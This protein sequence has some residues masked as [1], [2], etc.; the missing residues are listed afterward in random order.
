MVKKSILIMCRIV[1]IIGRIAKEICCVCN[2]IAL[3]G[4]IV[5]CFMNDLVTY[6]IFRNV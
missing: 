6:V 4:R 2:L 5:F 3:Y 1:N